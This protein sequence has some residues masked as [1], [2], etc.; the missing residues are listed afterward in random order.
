MF[1]DRIEILR[2]RH[3][4]KLTM[5]R[6][7]NVSSFIHRLEIQLKSNTKLL[8]CRFGGRGMYNFKYS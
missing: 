8:I 3:Y 5:F 4:K 7:Q 2:G 6:I 1:C